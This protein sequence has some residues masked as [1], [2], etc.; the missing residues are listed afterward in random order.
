MN[1]KKYLIV[2]AGWAGSTIAK[3]LHDNG[4]T[5]K[6]VEKEDYIGGHSS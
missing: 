3:L 2:G 6:I 1:R 5:V 4:N